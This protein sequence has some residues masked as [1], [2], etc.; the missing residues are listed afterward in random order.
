MK[1]PTKIAKFHIKDNHEV[2]YLGII[3][4]FGEYKLDSE[5]SINFDSNNIITYRDNQ[6]TEEYYNNID[7]KY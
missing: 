4:T 2:E 7:L 6:V 3:K 5:W 1:L